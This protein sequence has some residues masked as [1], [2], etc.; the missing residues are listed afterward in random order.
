MGRRPHCCRFTRTSRLQAIP[1]GE[2]LR[3][4]RYERALL[5]CGRARSAQG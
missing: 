1:V 5:R 3:S 4:G 2:R